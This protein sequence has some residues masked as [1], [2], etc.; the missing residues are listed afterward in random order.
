MTLHNKQIRD[1]RVRVLKVSAHIYA[2]AISYTPKYHM[3]QLY[4]M[5]KQSAIARRNKEAYFI[6][7]FTPVLNSKV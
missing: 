6:Q 1:P 4:K 5:N 3:F 7:K 2:C